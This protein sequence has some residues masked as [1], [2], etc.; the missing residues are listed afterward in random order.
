MTVRPASREAV[1]DGV[2]ALAILCVVVGHMVFFHA[3]LF[4]A[5]TGAIFSRPY[6]A[7][8]V[9]GGMA[10]D[11]FFVISGYLMGS[12]LFR[13]VKKTGDLRV[14][15]FYVRRFLRLIP[16]YV[17]AM[18]LGHWFM[19]H[20]RG[21]P[22]GANFANG[23]ANFFYVNNFLPMGK[24]YMAWCWSLAIEEQFYLLLPVCIL[25][26]MGPG[27]GRVR[28]LVCLMALS[29][30]TRFTIDHYCGIVPPMRLDPSSPEFAHWFDVDYDK[31]W[32]RFGGLLAGI[33]GAYL[34]CYFP[35][36]L[37]GFFARTGLITAISLLSLVICAH[38]AMTSSGSGF[39]NQIPLLARELWWAVFRDVFSLA[40]IFLI[41][42]AIHTPRLLGGWPRRFLS[43]DGFYPIAQLSYTIYLG[44]AMLFLWLFPRCAH[45][46]TG[47]LGA[48]GAMAVGCAFGLVATVVMAL[49]LHLM[50]ERPCMRLRSRPAVLRMIDSL[51]RP[52]L[53][54]APDKV[55]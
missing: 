50:I 32:M 31:P 9:N 6:A 4:P 2:R 52:K 28:I 41:L 44:H 23:W 47:R 33:T 29:V 21:Y 30:A 54:L 38:I 48:W 20:L 37:K 12:I 36:Q 8:V 55:G 43:W 22:R 25:L 19:H 26:F 39:F 7:W 1:V 49:S 42:A 51:S 10:V 15:R 24:Q 16:V 27:K 14:A 53:D 46:F 45:L 3:D 5:Q 35:T 18:I 11:V 17:V 34:S 40:T 13:E